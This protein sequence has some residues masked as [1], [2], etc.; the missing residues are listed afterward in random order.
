MLKQSKQAGVQLFLL[1]EITKEKEKVSKRSLGL[2]GHKQLL[3]AEIDELKVWCRV[4]S[5]GVASFSPIPFIPPSPMRL[6]TTFCGD[7]S[8]R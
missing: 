2:D 4:Q 6:G 8:V 5:I 3:Q 7:H 1:S